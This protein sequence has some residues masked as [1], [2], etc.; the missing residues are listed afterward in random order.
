M[1]LGFAKCQHFI[2]HKA[3]RNDYVPLAT[4]I[5]SRRQ[6]SWLGSS[7]FEIHIPIVLTKYK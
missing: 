3:F 1:S 7:E 4:S 5:L 6:T 2:S